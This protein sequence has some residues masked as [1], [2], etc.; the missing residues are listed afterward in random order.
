MTT[1]HVSPASAT[2]APAATGPAPR[3]RRLPGT[4]VL[5]LIGL[6]VVLG[7]WQV[8]AWA[9]WVDPTFSSSP[10]G[11]ITALGDLE[12][13]GDLWPPL[14]STV[15][16]VFFGMLISLAVGIP[17]RLLIA[18]TRLLYGLTQPI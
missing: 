4:G 15:E 16:S 9:G 5:G 1:T 7:A 3:R 10:I 8:S 6:V 13:S 11:A 2:A 18:R 14:L 12:R 17:L